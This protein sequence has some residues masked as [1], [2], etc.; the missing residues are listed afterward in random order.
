[1]DVEPLNGELT[2]NAIKVALVTEGEMTSEIIDGESKLQMESAEEATLTLLVPLI[3]DSSVKA[4]ED[5]DDNVSDKVS[6]MQVTL[7]YCVDTI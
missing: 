2:D 7:F 6:K 4:L 3:L 1:M 5:S